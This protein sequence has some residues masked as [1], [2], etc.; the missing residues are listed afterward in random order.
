M[1]VID[2]IPLSRT[3]PGILSYRS[4]TLLPEGSLVEVTVRKTKTQGIVVGATPVSEAKEMLKRAHFLL[5]RSIPSPSG[6]LSPDILR[7]ATQTAAFHATSVGNVLGALFAEYVRLDLA[8][9]DDDLVRGDGYQQEPVEGS[10]EERGVRYRE[11]IKDCFGRGKAVLLVV[12]TLPELEYWK[13]STK[14]L[15][16][17]VLSGKVPQ[18]RRKEVLSKATGHTGLII[19]TP[20]FSWTP[21]STVGLVIA[22]RVSAG[23][24]TLQ[25][26]PYLHMVRALDALCRARHISFIVGDYPLPLEFQ[27]STSSVSLPGGIEVIDARRPKDEHAAD[28]PWRALP[29]GVL[30]RMREELDSGGRVVVL[31]ARK[32]Y[33]PGVVCRDCGQAQADS[34]GV[35]YTFSQRGG[36]RIFRTNDGQSV[37]PAAQACSRCGSWNLLPLGIGSERVEEELRDVFEDTV[38]HVADAEVLSRPK[39]AKD[40]LLASQNSG[41]ITIGTEALLPFLLAYDDP[42]RKPLLVIASADSL[43][44]LPFWRA[45]ERF[46]RL[47][48]YARG[49]GKKVLLV[50]RR[51]EDTAVQALGAASPDGFWEEER[52]MRSALRYPP[53]G[54]LITLRLQGSE[55]ALEAP[56]RNLLADLKRFGLYQLPDRATV[57]GHLRR[58]FALQLSTEEWPNE[59]LHK[60]LQAVPPSVQV[61][62]N[63]ESL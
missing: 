35:P 11:E 42:E 63:P 20:S 56:S 26:R 50:T 62:V 22:D 51:P 47:A 36:E 17:L 31:A 41:T 59:E 13:R 45:R 24:Y 15:H 39:K 1:Y 57:G 29:E 23:T 16:P 25:K 27:T 4:A 37:I 10:V 28:G 3:A 18:A 58:T 32:G 6:M 40:V 54:V 14:D 30:T 34:R 61:Q 21:I 8:L 55:R 2:V 53:Y 46:I 44:S 60:Y 52:S 49:L 7:A 48:A 9:P 38:L 12:P 19:A 43:L 33:A 5:A